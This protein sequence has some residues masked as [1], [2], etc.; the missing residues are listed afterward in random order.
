[1]R[2]LNPENRLTGFFLI[3]KTEAILKMRKNNS[4]KEPRQ[5]SK[6]AAKI[7]IEN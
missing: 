5:F 4:F 7:K 1:V 3:L 2:T 6:P